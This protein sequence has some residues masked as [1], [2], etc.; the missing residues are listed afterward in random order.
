MIFV[1]L[2]FLLS[3]FGFVVQVFIP[4]IDWAW[5]AHIFAVPVVFFACAISLP[6]PVMLI[7]AFATGLVWDA[8]NHVAVVFPDVTHAA[9]EVDAVVPGPGGTFGVSVLFYALL[10][11]MMHGVRP[12]FRRGRWEL[13]VLMTGAGTFLLLVLEFLFLNFRRAGFSMPVEAWYSM[14]ATGVLSM[15]IAPFVFF[16]IDRLA[17]LSGYRIRYEGLNYRRRNAP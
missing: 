4:D 12:L 6:F 10:G 9:L 3:G 14:G 15:T 2:L 7:F 13:P 5:H 11:A 1:L 8:L 17:K 16:L